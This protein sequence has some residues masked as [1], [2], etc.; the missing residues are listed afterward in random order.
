M[1]LIVAITGA[2]GAIYGIKIL[3]EL[4]SKDVE[5][6]LIISQW[7]KAIIEQE[8]NYSVEQ[9]KSIA[10]FC[11]E[12]NDMGAII[13]SGSFESAG[14]IIAPCSMKTLAAVASG[15][16]ADLV[17]RASDVMI[18]E[19]R[20]LVMMVR[21]TPFNAIHLENMLKL[22]QLGVVIMPPL[23]AF[24]TKPKSIDDIVKDT[25]RKALGY[26]GV[27]FADIRKWEG[28]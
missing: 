15:Y 27:Q 14:M 25:I 17:T 19:K 3:E 1:R 10:D 24:Y 8:T 22:A 5:T 12:E 6:H 20:K 9:V 21:E 26:F 28:L 7:G 23:P 2:S 4:R 18:K 11:Y 16:A 13:S